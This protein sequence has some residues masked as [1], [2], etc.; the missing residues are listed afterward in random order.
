MKDI[1]KYFIIIFHILLGL[2][3]IFLNINNLLHIATLTTQNTDK[4]YYYGIS[5]LQGF[6]EATLGILLGLCSV[7]GAVAFRKDKRWAVP[8]LP[9]VTL[10]TI[11]AAVRSLIRAGG[12]V[13]GP[14]ALVVII[15]SI[16][17]IVEI[18]YITLRKQKQTN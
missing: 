1:M 3:I 4:Q 6:V 9:I 8:L 17:L 7:V 11:M 13:A 10:I 14:T 15:L 12:L 18:L 16:F 5:L 2:L